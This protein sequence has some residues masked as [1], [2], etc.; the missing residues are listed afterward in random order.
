MRVTHQSSAGAMWIR[1][2]KESGSGHNTLGSELQRNLR[3]AFRDLIAINKKEI[4]CR[5]SVPDCEIQV[6]I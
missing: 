2:E 4:R 6:A 1:K 3:L 5:S